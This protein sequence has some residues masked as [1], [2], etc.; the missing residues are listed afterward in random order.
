MRFGCGR[1]PRPDGE[2]FESSDFSGQLK[3]ES[4]TVVPAC[5]VPHSLLPDDT[6][7]GFGHVTFLYA[8]REII[9]E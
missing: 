6:T 8:I 3:P 2:G 1:W 5:T 4:G 9:T 7:G